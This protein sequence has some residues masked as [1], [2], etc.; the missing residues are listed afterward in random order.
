MLSGGRP[1]VHGHGVLALAIRI[2]LGKMRARLL[3][4]Q[5]HVMNRLHLHLIATLSFVVCGFASAQS[6]ATA[7]P[8]RSTAEPEV[9]VRRA[10]PVDEPVALTP[11]TLP[12]V[13]PADA[14][15]VYNQCI[16]ES[17]VVAITF[18][19]GPDPVGTPRLL[20][21]LKE[22]GIKATFFLIGRSVTTWPEVVRRIA[23]E[24]HEVANHSW[25]HP[26]LTSLR[27]SRVVSE[28]QTTHD[29]IVKACGVAPLLYRPPYGATRLSQ[30][31]MI[32]D[33]FRY[34]CILWDVDPLDWQSP[35][36]STKVHD[37]VLAQTKAGSII[38]CHDIHHETVDAMPSTLDDLKARGFQFVTVTQ[39]INLE[40]QTL[41]TRAA[42]VAA[43][44]AQTSGAPAPPAVEAGSQLNVPAAQPPPDAARTPEAVK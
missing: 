13:L 20:D 6:G 9:V 32:H 27:E 7:P 22:R 43:A 33:R 5:S 30:Q 44:R 4:S 21:M 26:Q 38:L 41:A 17:Q 1:Q 23:A 24:G 18:D 19:D 37:R 25:S 36:S 10:I 3:T 12:R 14:K 29:A 39:L 31:K 40:S 11:D 8:A 35:R 28:L 16:V 15:R 2:R 34:P 42:V